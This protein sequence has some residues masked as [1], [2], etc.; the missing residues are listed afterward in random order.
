M[1]P[2]TPAARGYRLLIA[3]DDREIGELLARYFGAR[4]LEVEVANDGEAAWRCFLQRPPDVVLTD[5]MMPRVDGRAL[6]MRIRS[7]MTRG[8]T[9]IVVMAAGLQTAKDEETLLADT[10]VDAAFRKPLPLKELLLKLDLLAGQYS[11]KGRANS[12]S[13]MAPV[14]GVVRPGTGVEAAGKVSSPRLAPVGEPVV[15]P[16]TQPGA[17]VPSTPPRSDAPAQSSSF[18]A[19]RTD[20]GSQRP[21]FGS[22]TTAPGAVRVPTSAPASAPPASG[23]GPVR[24]STSA[25][26]FGTLRTDPGG[27]RPA[28][29]TPSTASGAARAAR[30][31]SSPPTAVRTAFTVPGASHLDQMATMLLAAFETRAN[32]LLNVGNASESFRI[33]VVDGVVADV[34]SSSPRHHE[35]QA[36]HQGGLITKEQAGG[37]EGLERPGQAAELAVSR[38]G[39]KSSRALQTLEAHVGLLLRCALLEATEVAPPQPLPG[40]PALMTRFQI[41]PVQAVLDAVLHLPDDQVAMRALEEHRAL[42]L[43]RSGVFNERALLFARLRPSSPVPGMVMDMPTVAQ[44]CAR[45]A[46]MAGGPRELLALCMADA[47]QLGSATFRPKQAARGVALGGGAVDWDASHLDAHDVAIREAVAREWIRTCATSIPGILN[48]TGAFSAEAVTKAHGVA[49]SRFGPPALDSSDLGPAK[50]YLAMVR[51]R[52]DVARTLLM[53]KV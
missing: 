14:A 1:E 13:N 10:K 15:R 6:I 31:D 24:P 53:E 20:P 36:L 23:A 8:R 43:H 11:G 52:R 39:V 12:L 2:S 47:L 46:G 9:P 25:P 17:H 27:P 30:P 29:G 35:S 34:H 37:L 42:L 19:L 51:D 49:T 3:E 22:P 38:L 44:A 4:G 18:G 26:A 33:V 21:A 48:L 45:M 28:F 5:I 41:D 50:R 32:A 16:G 7:H 40:H